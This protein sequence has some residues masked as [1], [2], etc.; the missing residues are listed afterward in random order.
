MEG[1]LGSGGVRVGI[2]VGIGVGAVV[3]LGEE[4]EVEVEV[5]F[6]RSELELQSKLES[7]KTRGPSSP[8]NM[9]CGATTSY[10]RLIVKT[11]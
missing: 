5:D 9:S 11:V 8:G 3:G 7:L 6:L 10:F 2:G 1:A 4:V